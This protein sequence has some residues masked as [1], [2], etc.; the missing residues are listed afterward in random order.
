MTHD[1]YKIG[2]T[3]APASVKDANGDIV[4]ALCRRCGRAEIELDVPCT[5]DRAI[6]RARPTGKPI[7]LKA[8]HVETMVRWP[9][10]MHELAKR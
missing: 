7:D 9:T 8:F 10:M 1:I 3:D 4:L 5:E 2:D 6:K